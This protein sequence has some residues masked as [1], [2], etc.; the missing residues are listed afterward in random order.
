MELCDLREEGFTIMMLG[1]F[2]GHLGVKSKDN[3]HGVIGDTCP[4]NQNGSLF[5]DF[6]GKH[7]LSI[8]NNFDNCKGTFTRSEGGNFS[9]VDFGIIE[10]S[11]SHMVG[12]VRIDEGKELAQGSDHSLIQVKLHLHGARVRLKRSVDTTRFQITDRTDFSEFKLR[13]EREM[14]KLV[15]VSEGLS[16][17]ERVEKL[18]TLLLKTAKAC[19]KLKQ[20]PSK[21]RNVLKL[22][23]KVKDSI[24]E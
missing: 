14:D 10:H 16:I 7:N 3:P 6:V 5:L 17:V 8:I 2:N 18:Q 21:I 11:V 23:P 19:F 15:E 12:D 4:R 20:Y 22:P 1:D 13:V 24:R 9:V